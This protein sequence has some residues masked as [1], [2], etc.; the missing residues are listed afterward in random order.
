M[1][2]FKGK[3]VFSNL[4]LY[5]PWSFSRCQKSWYL[6][7]RFLRKKTAPSKGTCEGGGLEEYFS[8]KMLLWCFF[9]EL[10]CHDCFFLFSPNVQYRRFGFWKNMFWSLV[11][12][13]C[14]LDLNKILILKQV[15]KNI[16]GWRTASKGPALKTLNISFSQGGETNIPPWKLRYLL[17]IGGWKMNFAVKMVPF[18]QTFVNFRVG[19][20][21]FF[22][23]GVQPTLAERHPI[24]SGQFFWGR[25]NQMQVGQI[26]ICPDHS[27]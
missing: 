6:N 8:T 26:E 11:R 21:K 3:Q 4:G 17:K 14:N 9:F 19:N 16:I 12:T 13:W 2:F 5:F 22:F 10:K 15:G 1:V 25:P 27:G 23:P 7:L 24:L 18:Q 20:T